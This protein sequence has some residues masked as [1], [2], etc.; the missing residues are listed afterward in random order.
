MPL[1]L[2]HP[3]KV[4]PKGRAVS[5]ILSA[6]SS[7][8]QF[9]GEC[10]WEYMDKPGSKPGRLTFL[11]RHSLRFCRRHLESLVTNA[12]G[13]TSFKMRGSG[14]ESRWSS[15]Y[16]GTIAQSDRAL[17]HR[18]CRHHYCIIEY[19]R[20]DRMEPTVI[21]SHYIPQFYQRGFHLGRKRLDLG[22]FK[23][24]CAKACICP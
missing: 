13:T 14:F 11:R 16:M 20:I 9:A 5:I 3:V 17:F 2:H 22:L 23:R 4:W 8:S 7:Q 1:G 6:P 24:R 18:S 10:W 21:Q 19:T 15:E 12:D